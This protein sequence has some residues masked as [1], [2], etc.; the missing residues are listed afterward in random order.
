MGLLL[1]FF[2]L[3]FGFFLLMD[4]LMSLLLSLS[5]VHGVLS[6]FFLLFFLP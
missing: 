4:S 2:S 1:L 5:F 3:F 6:F